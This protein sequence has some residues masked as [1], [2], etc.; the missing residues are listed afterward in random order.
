MKTL[1][2]VMIAL[3]GL[4]SMAFAQ[5]WGEPTWNRPASQGQTAKISHKHKKNKE[6]R[7]IKQS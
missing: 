1:I 6:S 2:T 5:E 7:S 4:T 3:V